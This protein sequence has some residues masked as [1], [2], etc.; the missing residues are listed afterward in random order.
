MQF[1]SE[2]YGRDVFKS[3]A[4]ELTHTGYTDTEGA[5]CWGHPEEA[6]S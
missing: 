6:P 3:L 4:G 1:P 2:A 5:W